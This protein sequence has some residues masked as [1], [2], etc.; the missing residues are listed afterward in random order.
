M[1]KIRRFLQTLLFINFM[2][3]LYDG[4]RSG[5][6]VAIL[7]NGILVLVVIAAEKNEVR[8]MNYLERVEELMDMGLDEETACREASAELYP[9]TYNAD[10]Y[11]E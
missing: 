10:D 3:G 4:M 11:D 9:E 6:L 1:K 2:V 5:N 7:A 8:R